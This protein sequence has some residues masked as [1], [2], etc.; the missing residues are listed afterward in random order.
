VGRRE[1]ALAAI[2]ES[3]EIRRRLAEAHH[4]VFRSDLAEALNS[5]SDFLAQLGRLDEARAAKNEGEA[6][7]SILNR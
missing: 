7:L 5:Q 2:Q 1:E 6:V 3:V 4:N